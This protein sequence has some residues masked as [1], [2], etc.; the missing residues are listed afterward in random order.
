MQYLS[1]TLTFQ[2]FSWSNRHT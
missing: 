2:T 1:N